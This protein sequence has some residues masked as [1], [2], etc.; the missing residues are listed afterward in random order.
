[1]QQD[2]S[3]DKSSSCENKNETNRMDERKAQLERI[4][5][6]LKNNYAGLEKKYGVKELSIIGSYARCD[7]TE[8]SDLDIMVDFYE[9]I[10]WEVV[11]L[12]DELEQLPGISV[13]LVL[14]AGVIQ[15]RRVFD[16]ILEDAVY[17]KA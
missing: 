13:D 2:Y 8:E 15:R 4:V 16:G 12:R 17:V 1:M 9:P 6:T 7:Q 10:G 3:M 5:K 11:D 14:K